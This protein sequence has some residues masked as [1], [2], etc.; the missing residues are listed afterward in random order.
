[1]RRC[2]LGALH[3]RHP[4]CCCGVNHARPATARTWSAAARDG[5]PPRMEQALERLLKAALR[6]CAGAA[7]AGRTSTTRASRAACSARRTRRTGWL[8]W[9]TSCAQPTA[10]PSTPTSTLRARGRHAAHTAPGRPRGSSHRPH[11]CHSSFSQR[12]QAPGLLPG[13]CPLWAAKRFFRVD[14]PGLVSRTLGSA[15]GADR[16]SPGCSAS[17][18]AHRAPLGERQPVPCR[19]GLRCA[20][21]RPSSARSTRSRGWST[22][23]SA[24][25]SAPCPSAPSTRRATSQAPRTGCTAVRPT[26]RPRWE[27]CP[28]SH[29]LRPWSCVAAC[30]GMRGTL[31]CTAAV[32]DAPHICQ[33]VHVRVECRVGALLRAARKLVVL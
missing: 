30:A 14:L 25:A 17:L 10:A 7:L 28:H 29:G 32:H 1:M 21:R 26:D 3:T 33:A 8:T 9:S 4:H 27:A 24:T 2:A 18:A 22:S 20:A 16:R 13:Q 11:L 12:Y 23:T 31:R 5:S 19:Q 15:S 6:R